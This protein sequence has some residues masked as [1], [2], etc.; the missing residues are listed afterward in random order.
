MKNNRFSFFRSIV[1]SAIIFMAFVSSVSAQNFVE[2]D[3]WARGGKDLSFRSPDYVDFYI[4]PRANAYVTV[5]LVDPDGYSQ[6]IYPERP[7]YHRRLRGGKKYRLSRLL[8]RHASAYWD[9]SGHAAIS[10]IATRR[11]VFLNDWLLDQ[12][13]AYSNRS[14]NVF[15]LSLSGSRFYVGARFG[16][17]WRR[18][19]KGHGY[20][21][22]TVPFFVSRN[23]RNRGHHYRKWADLRYSRSK[24]VRKR[25]IYRSKRS[26]WANQQRYSYMEPKRKQGRYVSGRKPERQ[27]RQIERRNED[28]RRIKKRAI[29]RDADRR[30]RKT[31]TIKKKTVTRGKAA[32]KKD[33]RKKRKERKRKERK[34]DNR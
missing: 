6:V 19:L 21:S 16:V 24:N 17:G 8:A 27:K 4:R 3:V 28:S 25:K 30:Q 5:M 29:L 11:P 14:S 2:V 12:M 31:V 13:F 18:H 32:P 1:I 7:E 9:I 33:E 26:L 10:V 15:E 22:H 34:N 20:W 23:Y